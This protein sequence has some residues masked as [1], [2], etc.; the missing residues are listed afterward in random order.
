MRQKWNPSLT[1]KDV[2]D[3]I[4]NMLKSPQPDAHTSTEAEKLFESDLTA[5]AEK[6]RELTLVHAV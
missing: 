5:F 4:V 6:A 2:M 1:L 3:Y